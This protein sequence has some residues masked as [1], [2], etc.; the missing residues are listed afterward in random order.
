MALV[1]P[2][3]RVLDLNEAL[4]LWLGIDRA[5]ATGAHFDEL[6][7]VRCPEIGPVLARAW[8]EA[9]P[10]AEYPFFA[11]SGSETHWLRLEIA[12]NSG[13]W[14]VRLSSILP[15][16]RELMEEGGAQ[17]GDLEKQ[18]LRIRLLRAESQLDK[19]IQRWP[20]VLFSQRAD[21]SFQYVNGEI[22]QLTGLSPEAW[23]KQP[24]KFWEVVHEA[25]VEELQRQCQQA[26]RQP[27]GVTTTYR[28]RHA[29]T[30]KV[31]YI[32][33]YRQAAVSK[34]GMVLGYDGV[35][36]DITR[37]TIAEKRLSIAA[38]K[39]TLALL[40][41]GLAHDFNNLMS[42]ILSLTE[43]MIAQMGP[44]SPH[45]PTLA[46]VKQ[47]SLQASQLIQRIVSLHRSKT[48]VRQYLDLNQVVP[49]LVEL[50]CKVLPRRIRVETKLAEGQLP[51][52]MDGVEFRQVVLNLALNAAD[53][54]PD[55]GVLT[56]RVR[57]HTEM[58]VLAHAQGKF[59]RLP[60]VCLSVQDDGTGISERHLAHI[61]DPFFTTKPLTKG[62]G[63]G[64]YNARVFVEE[65]AG[66][67]S[68]DSAEGAGATFHLWLPQADFTEAERL[69][70]QNAGRRRCL[71]LVGQP[72]LAIDTVTEFLRTHNFYVVATH[73]P[74]RAIE[75]LVTDENS[76]NGV[77]VLAEPN[78]EEMLNLI[79]ELHDRK[80]ASRVVLQIIGGNPDHV[81]SRILERAQLVLGSND[82]ESVILKK[83]EALLTADIPT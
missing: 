29:G 57:A 50:V 1:D 8:A 30:G 26:A 62:S 71:L 14:F 32:L 15:P 73:T 17:D 78:D 22:E 70:V 56:F 38:W 68:V 58:Q 75:L 44:E 72:G 63:L 46:L 24:L 80:L 34:S 40:T 23:R 45:T 59:P 41:M 55:R 61:F 66:A 27:A 35:W 4:A 25:D 69:A 65:H 82:E 13:G 19:L 54:M 10:L 21:F 77:M 53:A 3:H 2:S 39:E 6:L 64:L 33:E 67:I 60:C 36:L 12:R 28:I 83:L 52:Y 43:L 37:Q 9:A 7:Q 76:L 16:L 42:G 11:V 5:Q 47:S 79:K 81:D 48:G 20:G 31:S 18:Q 74:A 51:V 49:E